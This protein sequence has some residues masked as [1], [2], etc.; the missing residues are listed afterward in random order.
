[1]SQFGLLEVSR[2]RL[3]PA[4]AATSYTACPMCEGHGL[5]RTTESAALV[6]LRKTHNRVAQGDVATLRVALP[7]DVATYLLNQKRD[8]LAQRDRR[9]ATRI[10]VAPNPG[11]MSHQSEI[12]T[13]QRVE[14]VRPP[15]PQ[16]R[17]GGVAALEAPAAAGNG[18]A[19]G[20]PEATPAANTV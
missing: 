9:C 5:V 19:T 7:P 13:Q 6:A 17:L 14:G 16:I 2:Q 12:E 15:V 1:I 8:D 3:R 20:E 11:L 10:H 18:A 4:A